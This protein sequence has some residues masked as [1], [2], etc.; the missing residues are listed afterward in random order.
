MK[1]IS[2]EVGPSKEWAKKL[3]ARFLSGESLDLIQIVMGS[4]VCGEKWI[5]E[6]R[7][8]QCVPIAQADAA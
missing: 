4:E 2:G 5:G 6:G 8:R 1:S 7:T 3:R